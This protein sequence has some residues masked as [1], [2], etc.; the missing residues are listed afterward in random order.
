MRNHKSTLKYW[1]LRNHYL[2]VLFV[3]IVAV[4]IFAAFYRNQADWQILVTVVGGAISLIYI[5]EKQ[6]L[7]E[8]RLFKELFT[9]FN[10]RYDALNEGLNAIAAEDPSR[11][12]VEQQ[13][14]LFDYFN[15][16]GEEYLYYRNGYVYPEVWESWCSGMKQ[17]L[18]CE[19]IAEL[20]RSELETASYYGFKLPEEV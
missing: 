18:K 11:L 14:V 5:I 17:Y 15:L 2:L 7:D 19:A 6:Q 13:S 16:C 9:E 1:L 4:I 20:W 8:A 12:T 10:A 3:I